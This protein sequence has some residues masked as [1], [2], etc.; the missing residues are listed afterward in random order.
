MIQ[1]Q[2]LIPID[3]NPIFMATPP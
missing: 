3:T 2:W 1:T